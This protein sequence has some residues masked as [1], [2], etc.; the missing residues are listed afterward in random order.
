MVRCGVGTFLF[1]AGTRTCVTA[2][3]GTALLSDPN[4]FCRFTKMMPIS[5]RDIHRASARSGHCGET[6]DGEGISCKSTDLRGSFGR[7]GPRACVY[8][9]IGCAQCSFVSL[10]IN[11]DDDCSWYSQC[12]Q[13]QQG[14]SN[15]NPTIITWQVREPNGTVTMPEEFVMRRWRE[16]TS[17]SA[18]SRP[19]YCAQTF[20]AGNCSTG[21]KGTWTLPSLSSCRAACLACPRCAAISYSRVERD[22]S[23][24]S[25]CDA[26]DLR[27]PP[28]NAPDYITVVVRPGGPIMNATDLPGK[29]RGESR[30]DR[31]VRL[32]L[33]TLSLGPFLSALVQWCEGADRLRRALPSHWRVQTVILGGTSQ[34]DP[35]NPYVVADQDS[36]GNASA[37]H[38]FEQSAFNG[39]CPGA[40][41]VRI[42]AAMDAAVR[43]SCRA[44][45]K[46]VGK[47]PHVR[48]YETAR[49]LR[50]NPLC[51]RAST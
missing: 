44:S 27:R 37:A 28:R 8:R 15:D 7:L 50:S 33:A 16:S 2:T 18:G 34:L 12:D 23:W 35:F 31:P 30:G 13:F 21:S 26:H 17:K 32:A 9:C 49:G 5:Y 22:C 38:L 41:L 39:V 14:A 4:F 43:V 40:R 11:A 47:T 42:R 19:G 25:R 36:S 46:C 20:R 45:A 6:R 10:G 51:L 3:R 1:A 29:A 24:Y 48:C